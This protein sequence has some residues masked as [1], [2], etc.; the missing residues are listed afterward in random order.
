MT[1]V[2]DHATQIVK[3]RTSQ[4]MTMQRSAAQVLPPDT[5]RE[6]AWHR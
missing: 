5:T 3:T 6:G 2:H 1:H 4:R